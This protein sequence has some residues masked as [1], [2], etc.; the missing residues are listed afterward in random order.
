MTHITSAHPTIGRESEVFMSEIAHARVTGAADD[1]VH[2]FLQ[3]GRDEL[4]KA[5]HDHHMGSIEQQVMIYTAAELLPQQQRPLALPPRRHARART[6]P[7]CCL[8]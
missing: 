4:E 8:T 3:G 1:D 6:H 2:I 7:D 5:A